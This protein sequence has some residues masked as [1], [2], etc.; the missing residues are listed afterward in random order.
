MTVLCMTARDHTTIDR[1]V[2]NSELRNGQG[3]AAARCVSSYQPDIVFHING[4]IGC[5]DRE[6]AA[7]CDMLLYEVKVGGAV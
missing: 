1:S 3:V 7:V 5:A 6:L 2:V 4:M